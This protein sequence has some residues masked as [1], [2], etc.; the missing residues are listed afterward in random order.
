MFWPPRTIRAKLLIAFLAIACVLL[1]LL[2][3]YHQLLIAARTSA[4]QSMSQR[5]AEIELSEAIYETMLQAQNWEEYISFP[6]VMAFLMQDAISQ[7]G[8]LKGRLSS[9]NNQQLL[10]LVGEITR[11][12]EDFYAEF[13]V[14]IELWEEKGL[15]EESG[16][17]GSMR[18]AAHA[19]EEQ[20][21]QLDQTA[22]KIVRAPQD[23][24]TIRRHEKDYFS[25]KDEKYLHRIDDILQE[26]QGRIATAPLEEGQRRELL[27]K[28]ERYKRAFLNLVH[29]D[30]LVV[31][32][33]GIIRGRVYA[34]KRLCVQLIRQTKQEM[35]AQA[36]AIWTTLARHIEVGV[37]FYLAVIVLGFCLIGLIVNRYIVRPLLHLKGAALR[38]GEDGTGY[39]RLDVRTDDE[40]GDLADAFRAMVR[41]LRSQSMALSDAKAYTDN[42]FASMT[43]TLLVATA[44]GVIQQINRTDL[45]GYS[46]QELLG[47]DVARLFLLPQQTSGN[48]TPCF[49]I[50]STGSSQEALLVRKGG[51]R[52]PVLIS[53]SKSSRSVGGQNLFILVVKD[54]T[55]IKAFQDQLE[56]A[57][58]KADVASQAKSFFVANISHEIRTPMN[59]ILNM[60]Y[61]CLHTEVTAQQ[62]DHL[63]KIH[64][65][66]RTLLHIVND[67]LD[68]SKIE[69]GKMVLERIP[70]HLDDVLSDLA[71]LLTSKTVFK[72]VEMIFSTARGVPRTL[73][74]DP[75]CLGQI[76][77]NLTNNALKFTHAGEV[78]LS[79]ERLEE[80]A[81]S[82]RLQFSVRDTGIGM[83]AE[84]LDRVFH[85]FSQADNSTTRQYG[86]TG[87]GLTICQYLVEGMGG[88][89]CVESSEGQGSHFFFTIPFGL[90]E[91]SRRRVLQPPTYAQPKQVLVV[92]DN[93]SSQKMLRTALESFSLQVL[94]AVSGLEG[95]IVLEKRAQEGHPVDLLLLDWHMPHMDGIQ[96]LWCLQAQEHSA[97]IPVLLMAPR[98]EHA[99][100]QQALGDRQPHGYLDKPIQLSALFDAVMQMFGEQRPVALP[101]GRGSTMAV[102]PN[103]SIGGARVLLVEDNE[104][105]Q[106]VGQ[107]LLNMAGV[108]TEIVSN[109]QEAVERA[110]Q[111]LFEL[112]LMDLN[113]PVLDG[114]QATK[115]I[116]ALPQCATLPVVAMT[117]N[118]LVQDLAR[119]WEAGMDDHV[120]KPIDPDQL[121]LALNKWI[122]PRE[123]HQPQEE[124]ATGSSP[125]VER[126]N[127]SA[128]PTVPGIDTRLGLRHV[129][130]SAS[131]YRSMLTGWVAQHSH[132]LAE[133]R[134][135][136]SQGDMARAKVLLHT[137]KGIAGTLGA[138]R[139]A[140]LM[141]ELEASLP[142]NLH[143][144]QAALPQ[145]LQEEFAQAIASAQRLL[146]VLPTEPP[147]AAPAVAVDTALVVS[148]LEQLAPHI[149]RRRPKNCEP[150]LEQLAQAALTPEM[151]QE[152][153]TLTQLIQQ[154]SMKEAMPILE[155]LLASLRKSP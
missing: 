29:Q 13:L 35:T 16:M 51:N 110:G 46:S 3:S 139:L 25:R 71:S 123:R 145:A 101:E 18:R 82:V 119:C 21:E 106:Q 12:V 63:E 64:H 59:A 112:V 48:T 131:L 28:L 11:N 130:G 118:V 126:V 7:A 144:E 44:A 124:R 49:W 93:L 95:L 1:G 66:A 69:A 42:I 125:P 17:V 121:F 138:T 47:S 143:G 20:L 5:W 115:A 24:L 102:R 109:G 41:A 116:R 62:R 134:E 19:L 132:G 92:D 33:T 148:L 15:D 80:D 26:L 55:Q 129:A 39:W 22:S 113:L 43:D 52:V 31:Q 86:G 137:L 140:L 147:T 30:Q 96:T 100:I 10:N 97:R 151:A 135:S 91:H 32:Q 2:L 81:E 122:K 8:Q 114:Y 154:Y 146:S 103:P 84:Q 37:W 14:A 36:A 128:F 94:Q 136:F 70:F 54:I 117:A 133:L 153:Q 105:N 73:L 74:G 142:D 61:L 108:Q 78:L 53:C 141:A 98:V 38:I 57:R 75:T 149:S 88:T 120:A 79:V 107:A 104:I 90:P 6:K 60:A 111:G 45:L 65:A 40:I 83:T 99:R 89:L 77:I 150:L 67:V 23:Y 34:V 4:Q 68:F 50:H 87:L 155:R 27:H 76:L 127:P 72:D 56:Q 9:A 152:I 85:A 58:R